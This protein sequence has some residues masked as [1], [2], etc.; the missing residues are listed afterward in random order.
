MN[1][2][3]LERKEENQKRNNKKLK[4]AVIYAPVVTAKT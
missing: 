4:K 2:G 3:S 1:Y